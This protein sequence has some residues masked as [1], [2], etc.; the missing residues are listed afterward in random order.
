[1]V[2]SFGVPVTFVLS[3]WFQIERTFIVVMEALTRGSEVYIGPLLLPVGIAFSVQM[4][5]NY[6]H[7]PRPHT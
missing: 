1:M 3:Q 6:V 7:L 5:L 4:A 2:L